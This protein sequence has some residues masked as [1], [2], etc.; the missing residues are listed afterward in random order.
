M[1]DVFIKNFK[2]GGRL[3][4]VTQLKSCSTASGDVE[5]SLKSGQAVSQRRV[6]PMCGR[7]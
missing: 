6:P 4:C 3:M 7:E 2:D 1:L 5:G